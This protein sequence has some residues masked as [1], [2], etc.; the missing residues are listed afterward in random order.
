VVDH[1]FKPWSCQTKDY[2]IGISCFSA[3]LCIDGNFFHQ[4]QQNK[5]LPLTSNHWTQ[6]TKIQTDLA[7][8][9]HKN[10]DVLNEFKSLQHLVK[11][12]P[13]I[14]ILAPK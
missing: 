9:R 7:W 2:E 11:S 13:N 8:D 6:K 3:T 5:Q 14:V 10:V 12:A 4:Y 1:G